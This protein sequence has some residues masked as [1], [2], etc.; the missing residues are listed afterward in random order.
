[1]RGVQEN[2]NIGVIRSYDN[3]MN[4]RGSAMQ[5]NEQP[6]LRGAMR[7]IASSVAVVTAVGRCGPVG[8][9][10]TAVTSVSLEPASLLVCINRATRLYEAVIDSGQFRVSFLDA[11][12]QAVASKFGSSGSD[13]RFS[14]GSWH[15]G[16]PA[17]PRLDGAIAD[18]ACTLHSCLDHGTHGIFIGT[19]TDVDV[20]DGLPLL[21]CGSS[22]G[23]FAA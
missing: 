11:S 22:F 2:A 9:T 5:G 18:I 3:L 16:A 14:T 8:I 4:P 10:A 1:M 23:Q 20:R 13:A 21:Y 6:D 7:R 12:Q 15:L 19:V 17:G